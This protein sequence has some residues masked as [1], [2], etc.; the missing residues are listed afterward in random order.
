M[1]MI[2]INDELHDEL[3]IYCDNSPYKI[4]HTDFVEKCIKRELDYLKQG[5]KK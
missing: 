4:M 2:K 5:E 1:G 3:R